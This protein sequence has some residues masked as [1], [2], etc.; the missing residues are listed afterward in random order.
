MPAKPKKKRKTRRR[1]FDRALRKGAFGWERG[2]PIAH[3]L[4]SAKGLRMKVHKVWPSRPTKKP[5]S[6]DPRENIPYM[7]DF[8]VR[9][10]EA[11]SQRVDASNA[12]YH[13]REAKE[14]MDRRKEGWR[15]LV[16]RMVAGPKANKRLKRMQK[17]KKE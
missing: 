1:L 2:S 3:H 12:E 9:E 6:G 14:L 17:R 13:E 11:E 10:G 4:L 16:R 5:T 8:L 15:G 7:L